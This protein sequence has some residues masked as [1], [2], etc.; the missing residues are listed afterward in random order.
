MKVLQ[1]VQFPCSDIPFPQEVLHTC[2]QHHCLGLTYSS[3]QPCEVAALIKSQVYRFQ[4]LCYLLCFGA[5]LIPF[6]LFAQCHSQAAPSM[7]SGLPTAKFF[8]AN[9]TVLRRFK[10]IAS[11]LWASET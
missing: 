9:I 1:I 7:S 5:H 6:L 10:E 8:H 3:E 2:P 4:S 11:L